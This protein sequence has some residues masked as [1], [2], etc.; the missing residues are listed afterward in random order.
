M[1]GLRRGY[2]NTKE[3]DMYLMLVVVMLYVSGD[4]NLTKKDNIIERFSSSGMLTKSSQKN[5]K[6]GLTF[7]AK[8]L[9]ETYENLDKTTQSKI[10]KKSY[11]FNLKFT[12][13]YTSEKLDR[14][15]D[16]KLEYAVIKRDLFNGIIEDIAQVRCVNCN[17]S[18]QECEWY[19][20][21]EDS[22]KESSGEKKNCP[23]ACDL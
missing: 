19:L 2:L 21:L 10:D 20:I 12:D 7:I 13:S 18:Y 8:F 5:L 1:S 3:E 11:N 6:T 22:L 14:D 17:K 15:V 4:T 16:K 23:F 9:K